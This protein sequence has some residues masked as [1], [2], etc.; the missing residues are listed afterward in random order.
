MGR[1]P[2][3]DG[4]RTTDRHGYIRI[5][6]PDHPLADRGW[7]REHRAVLYTTI[8]PG[9][10]TCHRCG[11]TVEWGTTLEVDHL[12]HNRHNNQPTNLAPACRTCQNSHR[13]PWAGGLYAKSQERPKEEPDGSRDH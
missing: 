6:A 5:K 2:L 3:P 12:D 11:D 1:P 9:P 10:H 8:G 4:T 7:V 13:R